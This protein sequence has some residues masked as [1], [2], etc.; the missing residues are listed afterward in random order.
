MAI[1]IVFHAVVAILAVGIVA[2][3]TMDRN[4]VTAMIKIIGGVLILAG[5]GY[6]FLMFLETLKR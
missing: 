6:L 5:D 4:P 1:I 2:S 3:G